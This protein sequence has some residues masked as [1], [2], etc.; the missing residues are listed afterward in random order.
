MFGRIL[1]WALGLAVIALLAAPFA[2][3]VYHRHTL[4]SDLAQLADP[5]ARAALKE[6]YGSL[7]A[8]GDDLA[9]RCEQIYG[10]SDANCMR[11]R[12]SLRD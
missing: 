2:L 1:G 3:D 6:R 11:Y 4:N 10:R 8:F 5:Q 7:A 12:L 9:R